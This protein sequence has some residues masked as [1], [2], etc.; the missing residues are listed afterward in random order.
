MDC[1]QFILGGGREP[2]FFKA[3]GSDVLKPYVIQ[4]ILFL[5]PDLQLSLKFCITYHAV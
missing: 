3:D 5:N 2:I 1:M 4:C